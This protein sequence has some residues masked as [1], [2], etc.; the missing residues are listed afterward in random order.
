MVPVD[1]L[2]KRDCKQ[3]GDVGRRCRAPRCPPTAPPFSRLKLWRPDQIYPFILDTSCPTNP[4]I[5]LLFTVK[6]SKIFIIN[7]NELWELR[8]M[9]HFRFSLQILNQMSY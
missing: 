3:R 9:L 7:M 4:K 1:L 6:I 8:L 2:Q 5:T